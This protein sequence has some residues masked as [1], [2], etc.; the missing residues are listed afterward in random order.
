MNIKRLFAVA[1][2]V[3]AIFAFST[4]PISNAAAPSAPTVTAGQ[5]PAPVIFLQDNSAP[6]R[7][8]SVYSDGSYSFTTGTGITKAGTGTLRAKG[9]TAILEDS[10]ADARI[11]VRADS[12]R[13][14]GTATLQ[15]FG[16]GTFTITDKTTG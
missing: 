6:A 13:Q 7:Q 5:L 10:D 2:I 3:A 15:I 8:V 1:M 14:T 4:P 9:C 11:V 16:V 12:C